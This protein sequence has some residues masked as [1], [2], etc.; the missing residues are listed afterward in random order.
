MLQLALLYL[1]VSC[2]VRDVVYMYR[3]DCFSCC[4]ST[5]TS[6]WRRSIGELEHPSKEI[7]WTGEAVRITCGLVCYNE[8]Q[9]INL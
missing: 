2:H 8:L 4:R 3:P 6:W 9:C 5:S 1:F 7:Y